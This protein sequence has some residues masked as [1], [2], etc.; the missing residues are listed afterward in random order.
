MSA[1]V[2]PGR[3]HG[4]ADAFFEWQH[5]TGATKVSN[6]TLA[7]PVLFDGGLASLLSVQRGPERNTVVG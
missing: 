7:V 4:H 1:S 6:G 2:E 3:W 5:Y